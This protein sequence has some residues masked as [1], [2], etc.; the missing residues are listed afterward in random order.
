MR[1]LTVQIPQPC[2]ESWGDMQPAER[3]RFCGSCQ[4]TV[5]DYTTLSDQEL[6][7]LLRKTSEGSCG[8]FR[9]EQLNRPLTDTKP[10]Q[11]PVWYRWVGVLSISLFGWHTTQA[12]QKQVASVSV[13]E[14]L[15]RV[16]FEVD[17][18][19]VRTSAPDDTEW[20]VSGRVMSIDSAGNLS[21]IPLANVLIDGLQTRILGMP[22]V[23]PHT[24]TDSTGAFS[25]T[26]PTQTL[27][28]K[29]TVRVSTNDNRRGKATF[30]VTP[31]TTSIL[32]NDIVLYEI[33]ARQ[34]ITGGGIC[35]VKPPSFWQKV[36]RK[37]FR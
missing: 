10:E 36:K 2:P 29:L 35:L 12:Q 22:S 30:E 7:R 11:Y 17:A 4:K 3:G 25:L 14:P 8:R 19:S 15:E 28:T 37:L 23:L 26:V 20:P 32:L 16:R 27:V 24:Q 33:P 13:Q 9:D 1:S 6:I 21:A 34:E 5:V 31:A 18:I